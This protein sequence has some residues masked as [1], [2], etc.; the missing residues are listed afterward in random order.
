MLNV[1]G[2]FSKPDMKVRRM[3][4]WMPKAKHANIFDIPRDLPDDTIELARMA[5]KMMWATV[6]E[7]IQ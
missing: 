5:I 3:L 1:F 7:E 2:Q 6:P 4:Y